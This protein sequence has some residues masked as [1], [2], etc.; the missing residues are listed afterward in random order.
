MHQ[1]S[2][3]NRADGWPL[4]DGPPT[5]A[6]ILA[7]GR[8]RRLAPYTDY[9]PK[10]LLPL[11]GRPILATTLEALVFAGVHQVCLVTGHLAGQV[12]AFVGD[13]RAWGVEATCL[14]QPA[15]LGTAQALQ[16]AAAFIQGPTF[17]LAADYVLPPDYLAALKRAYQAGPAGIL[18]S[19]KRL[20]PAELAQRS[21]VRLAE[22]G[23]ILEIVE[24]PAPGAAPSP[25]GASLIYIVPAAIRDYLEDLRLSGR[26]EYEITDV[27][28]RMIGDGF[29]AA[30]LLQPAPQ[31][32]TP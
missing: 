22:D 4:P 27:I 2:L 31:E 29:Q 10:P 9:T 15:L 32:W 11:H 1:P 12:E 26:G 23:R 24:K 16:T 28:N 5:R 25:L 13:G 20:S 14:R 18:I 30:G 8:G 3:A 6:V 21:S 19:L 7:A 17:V